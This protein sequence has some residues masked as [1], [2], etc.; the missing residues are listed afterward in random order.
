MYAQMSAPSFGVAEDLRQRL[1][2]QKQFNE[3]SED[4]RELAVK[5]VMV[6]MREKLRRRGI[7][8][9]RSNIISRGEK[10]IEQRTYSFTYRAGF[11]SINIDA[12]PDR[13]L[14]CTEIEIRYVDAPFVQF[15]PGVKV[16]QRWVAEDLDTFTL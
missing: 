13:A 16:G 1:I 10:G 4:A 14:R 6:L 2:A 8:P 15:H 3:T 9:T 12:T 11:F 5:G 7:I